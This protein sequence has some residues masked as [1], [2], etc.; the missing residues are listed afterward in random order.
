VHAHFVVDKHGIEQGRFLSICRHAEVNF[1]VMRELH[2]EISQAHGLNI[3]AS[4]R[5]SRGIIEN[6]LRQMDLRAA[7]AAG[8][9]APPAPPPL[10]DG[11]RDRRL[12]ALQGFARQYVVRPEQ[13]PCH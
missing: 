11:E 1:D 3:L 10:F 2:A 6:P 4:S 8:K 7:H 9:A 12:G 13:H 5:L